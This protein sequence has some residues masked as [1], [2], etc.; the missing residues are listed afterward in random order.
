[1]AGIIDVGNMQLYS[2]I[3]AIVQGSVYPS[4]GE[5][6][7]MRMSLVNDGMPPPMTRDLIDSY[8]TPIFK[9][10]I[11]T[12]LPPGYP[13]ALPRPYYLPDDG[14]I[15]LKPVPVAYNLSNENVAWI[16]AALQNAI[17]KYSRHPYPIN[18]EVPN[19]GSGFGRIVQTCKKDSNPANFVLWKFY[20]YSLPPDV[21]G[22]PLGQQLL[23]SVL[24]LIPGGGLIGQTVGLLSN[25][26]QGGTTTT[27]LPPPAPGTGSSSVA[28]GE[29]APQS[30]KKS[31]TGLVV[32]LLL[33]A[34]AL[35]YDQWK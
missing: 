5:V 11:Q 27:N 2:R 12:E 15:V 20:D 24:S 6:G 18:W 22:D 16:M 14:R 29:P 21:G 34:G 4:E 10:D 28:V 9:T 35:T 32:L 23:G 17:N 26:V 8:V 19:Q 31:N 7:W 30:G 13:A 1:M 25:Y 3:K 33:A